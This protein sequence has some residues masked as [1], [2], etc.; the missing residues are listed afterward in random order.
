MNTRKF[1]FSNDLSFRFLR[2]ATF[3]VTRLLF[4]IAFH[5]VYAFDETKSIF[6][7]FAISVREIYLLV[8]VVDFNYCYIIIYVLVEKL[9][10]RGKYYQF[11]A[12]LII[13]SIADTILGGIIQYY[14]Y[15][16]NR[17]LPLNFAMKWENAIDFMTMG[18]PVTCLVF[19]SI[20]MCKTWY[21]KQEEHQILLFANAAA[22]IEVLK[23]Q[24]HPHFLFNTLNNI[25]SF[26]LERSPKAEELVL[27]L[28]D[29]L[30]YM[31][32]DCGNEFVP[33]EK[34]LKMLNDYIGLE[35]VRYGQR[36]E[37]DIRI[38]GD[39]THKSVSPLL[40]IPFIENSFKHGASQVLT[41]PWIKLE[42]SI[43]ENDLV[44]EIGNSKPP[45]AI[46]VNK[47]CGIGLQNVKKRLQLLY[48]SKYELDIHSTAE[49]FFV[50]L[51]IPCLYAQ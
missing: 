41:N 25:Y 38:N 8:F 3:W 44:L 47:K 45:A 10:R 16:I 43:S 11:T 46:S 40:M 31:I 51:K 29:M 1:I 32:D 6:E 39:Y 27:Q 2:H 35:Q 7:N 13:L 19:L 42:I 37:T 48:H 20:K 15:Y 22:E 49:T 50:H 30:K 4:V 28:S 18:P 23:A 21:L 36:L 9:F 14:N 34:E 12:W 24:I 5:F 26:T 33:L 17:S